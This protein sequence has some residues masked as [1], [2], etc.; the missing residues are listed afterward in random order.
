MWFLSFYDTLLW[1]DWN[2]KLNDDSFSFLWQTG[3]IFEV[4]VANFARS[5]TSR[6]HAASLNTYFLSIKLTQRSTSNIQLE[7][8]CITVELVWEAGKTLSKIFSSTLDLSLLS[9]D[10]KL[11]RHSAQ[12]SSRSGMWSLLNNQ[13]NNHLDIQKQ[14]NNFIALITILHESNTVFVILLYLS[15][16]M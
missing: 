2:L 15:K 11:V 5:L 16:T 3:I 4:E 9:L 1:H 14:D 6:R 7:I 12:H 10:V 8:R 13:H